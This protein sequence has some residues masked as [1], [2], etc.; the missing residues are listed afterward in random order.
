MPRIKA[1]DPEKATGKTR[2]LLGAVKQKFGVVPNIIRGLANSPAA[3][4]AY[5][6]FSGA[7]QGSSISPKLREQI[8]LAVGETNGCQYCVSAHSLL[9]KKVGIGNEEALESRRGKASDPKAQAALTFAGQLLEKRGWVSDEDVSALR[10]AGFGD[11]EIAEI[12]ATVAL[13]IFT[14]FFNHVAA[15]KID[16]PEA[17]KL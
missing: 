8:A 7:L 2:E 4:E 1:V 3:L 5:L 6:G 9:G 11:P 15:T 17:P 13:N 12:V 14:N 10:A 16:F